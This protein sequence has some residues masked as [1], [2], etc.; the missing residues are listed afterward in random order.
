MTL[1]S[2]NSDLTGLIFFL[3]G[4]FCAY[5]AQEKG[6]NAWFWFFA[7]ALLGPLTGLILLYLNRRQKKEQ[8]KR[9]EA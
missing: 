2:L 8:K 7:G 5:W 1:Q 4:I 3:F 6:R 9:R